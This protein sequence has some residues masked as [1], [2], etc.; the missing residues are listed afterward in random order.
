MLRREAFFTSTR[1]CC[2][3]SGGECHDPKC[4]DRVDR[5]KNAAIWSS[6]HERGKGGDISDKTL[7]ACASFWPSQDV[8]VKG[9]IAREGTTGRSL[10]P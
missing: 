3:I 8:A 7:S 4:R 5:L 6:C 1:M 2:I 10:C 9:I